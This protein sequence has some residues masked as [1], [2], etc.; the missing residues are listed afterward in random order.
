MNVSINT[1]LLKPLGN[2]I[3]RGHMPIRNRT[4]AW[5]GWLVF[6]PLG[7]GAAIAPPSPETTQT[8]LAALALWAAGLTPVY[9]EGAMARALGLAQQAALI[10]RLAEAE[11]EALGDAEQLEAEAAI[12][13]SAADLDEAAARTARAEAGRIRAER[14]AVKGALAASQEEAAKVEANLHEQAARDAR[15]VAAAAKRQRQ[16]AKAEEIRGRHSE[17]PAANKKK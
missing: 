15:A 1:G 17:R 5:D 6:F 4:G 14:V 7:G 8:T 10:A 9:L 13:R 16:S 2:G 11:Y 12:E 3:G